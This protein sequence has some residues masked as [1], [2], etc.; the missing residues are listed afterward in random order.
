MTDSKNKNT[1]RECPVCYEQ[2]SKNEL[3]CGKC[4]T[5]FCVK[6]VAKLLTPNYKSTWEKSV[7]FQWKC[8]MCRAVS[9]VNR[10]QLLVIITGS[11]DKM[12]AQ[13]DPY[14]FGRCLDCLNSWVKYGGRAEMFCKSCNPEIPQ[15]ENTSST[16]VLVSRGEYNRRVGA[17]ESI[18]GEN[19][20]AN[21]EN[22][23]SGMTITE[24]GYTYPP[25]VN[26]EDEDSD[27]D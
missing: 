22:E 19:V 6:C 15:V 16:G 4:D 13:L 10:V 11:W 3:Q 2:V 7:G 20:T 17:V 26:S 23:D 5:S 18:T 8:P 1:E 9:E 21:V 25:P 12:Y 14:C 27:D 24:N